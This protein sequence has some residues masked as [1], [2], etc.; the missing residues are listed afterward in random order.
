MRGVVLVTG[1]MSPTMVPNSTMANSKFTPGNGKS[2]FFSLSG[3][4]FFSMIRSKC[5]FLKRAFSQI[6]SFIKF[7]FFSQ[8][9]SHHLV[10]SHKVSSIYHLP[11]NHPALVLSLC[12]FCLFSLSV[13]FVCMCTLVL[14]VCLFLALLLFLRPGQCVLCPLSMALKNFSRAGA[15]FL[16]RQRKWPL[17]ESGGR[18]VL[19]DWHSLAGLYVIIIIDNILE[20]YFVLCV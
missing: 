4:I 3:P 9:P 14:S 7:V 6:K 16:L 11:P 8:L 18:M 2:V 17:K 15:I 19:R 10:N 20:V 12:L 1:S 5:N 13:C